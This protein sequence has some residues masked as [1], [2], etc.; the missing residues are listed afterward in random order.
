MPL[1][2]NLKNEGVA[3]GVAEG[4]QTGSHDISGMRQNDRNI[5]FGNKLELS[6]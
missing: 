6:L 2:K 1:I 3:E 4:V 5:Y